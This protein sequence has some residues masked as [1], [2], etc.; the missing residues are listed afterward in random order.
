MSQYLWLKD[1]VNWKMYSCYF[2]FIYFLP[3]SVFKNVFSFLYSPLSWF[4]DHKE[5][6]ILVLSHQQYNTSCYFI[7]VND[8]EQ[9]IT[10]CIVMFKCPTERTV[11]AAYFFRLLDP[12]DCELKGWFSSYMEPE[13]CVHL[14]VTLWPRSYLL[15]A[16]NLPLVNK[17]H[18]PFCFPPVYCFLLSH[19]S[20]AAIYHPFLGE[21]VEILGTGSGTTSAFCL[22]GKRDKNG[23]HISNLA[24][25]HLENF[26]LLLYHVL[27][28]TQTSQ[29]HID[30]FSM[31]QSRWL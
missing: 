28:L 17:W 27:F 26:S 13:G 31:Q 24:W 7:I 30:I 21:P 15:N 9:P 23:L 19:A 3:C 6:E 22:W 4:K 20:T 5:N 8:F 25:E 18:L 14:F 10:F 29:V 1:P 2:L 12:E 16:W 11:R